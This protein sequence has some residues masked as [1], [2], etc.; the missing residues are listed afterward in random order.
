L[1]LEW[2]S[3]LSITYS[4]CTLGKSPFAQIIFQCFNHSFMTL[5][6][7]ITSFSYRKTLPEDNSGN[8]GGYVFDC[9]ALPNPGRQ[10]VY[11]KKTGRD[12]EVIS[13]LQSQ[14]VVEE[15]LSAIKSVLTHSIS[16]YLERDFANLVV[17]FGCTG[18]QHRSVYCAERISDW[19]RH[20]YSVRVTVE[21][22]HRDCPV[23]EVL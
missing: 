13:F 23:F 21:L 6:I 17:S 8:G 11:K 3:Y 16:N 22:L 18:G 14:K 12:A 19:I 9:R 2:L 15:Y 20:E 4:A 5:K 10:E 1:R 7:I